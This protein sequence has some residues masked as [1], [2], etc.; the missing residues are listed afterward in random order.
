MHQLVIA[1]GT[2]TATAGTTTS[3]RSTSGCTS[4]TDSFVILWFII[5]LL[6]LKRIFFLR[7]LANFGI[8]TFIHNNWQSRT[9]SKQ[10]TL[11]WDG[12][13]ATL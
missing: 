10:T 1:T 12:L 9:Q 5:A 3:T 13:R 7:M 2:V 4:H 8:L 6:P 11:A